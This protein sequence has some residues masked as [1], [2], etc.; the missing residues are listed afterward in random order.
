[1]A[2]KKSR[3]NPFPLLLLLLPFLGIPEATW[4]WDP[5]QIQAIALDS[6]RLTPPDLYRQLRRNRESFLI[7]VNE[8]RAEEGSL[9]QEIRQGIENAGL[10]IRLHRPFNEISYRLG[11]VARLL[12]RANDPLEVVDGDPEE[13]RYR[14]DF[15]DYL[16]S[17]EPRVRVVFYGFRPWSKENHLEQVLGEAQ[18]RSQRFYPLVGREYRRVGFVPGRRGFDDR[19]TAFAI[20]SLIRSH[21]VSD[22]AEVLR[23]IW[24]STGGIDSRPRIPLRGH[25]S[26]PLP[27][28]S[29]PSRP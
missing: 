14:A 19:S 6:A 21:A 13:R 4:A 20:A 17:V 1:M 22:I 5:G 24:L 11:V 16:V 9:E 12:T 15:S 27:R 29:E 23:Y 8:V 26:I 2:V 25:H 18:T 3:R 7:G 10:A 28:A